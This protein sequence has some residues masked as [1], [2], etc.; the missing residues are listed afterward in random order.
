MPDDELFELA[1]RG[2]LAE[3]RQPR[4]RKCAAC[5]AD[6]K[7]QA[8]VDNF[9]G[10]W[11][12]T[13]RLASM[14]TDRELFPGFDDALARRDASRRPT[15]FFAS[16]MREDRSVARVPRRRLHVPQRA[17]GEALRHSPASKATSSAR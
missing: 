6:P 7:A 16:I 12:Q 14:N 11:L 10:Q 15:L 17:A 13:R 2:E 1:K 5:C 8:L 4:E 9:A 3:R